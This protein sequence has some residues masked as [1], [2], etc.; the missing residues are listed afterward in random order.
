M[1]SR[2]KEDSDV[3]VVGNG[4]S[5]C[6]KKNDGVSACLISLGCADLRC[7]P[8]T[9]VAC[10]VPSVLGTAFCLIV[11]D[12]IF[13]PYSVQNN[14]DL[15]LNRRVTLRR[16]DSY[17]SNI[18]GLATF[19]FKLVMAREKHLCLTQEFLKWRQQQGKTCFDSPCLP[20]LSPHC[21]YDC[22]CCTKDCCCCMSHRKHAIYVRG[23]IFPTSGWM[24]G[25]GR[26][27]VRWRR[28][29]GIKN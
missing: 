20:L 8:T 29:R 28:R 17:V 6:I 19:Y 7:S 4:I 9:A 11:P 16:I 25:G 5:L 12:S 15:P 1:G 23:Q 10:C 26:R 3:V 22:C 21:F 18:G 24:N 27:K 2:K 13:P 14:P